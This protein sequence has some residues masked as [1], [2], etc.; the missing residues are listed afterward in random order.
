V[1]RL[2]PE[3]RRRAGYFLAD[4]L[5]GEDQVST[6]PRFLVAELHVRDSPITDTWLRDFP[7]TLTCGVVYP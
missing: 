5:Q 7:T 3:E 1:V 4:P 2:G 6:S